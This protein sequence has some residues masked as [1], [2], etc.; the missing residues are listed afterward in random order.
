MV[1]KLQFTTK[2]FN[3]INNQ[4]RHKNGGADFI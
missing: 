1:N 4:P 2:L 3:Y